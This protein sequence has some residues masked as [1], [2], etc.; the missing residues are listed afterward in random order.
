MDRDRRPLRFGSKMAKAV[1]TRF[2][3]SI[4]R[5]RPGLINNPTKRRRREKLKKSDI[6]GEKSRAKHKGIWIAQ[7]ALELHKR[8]ISPKSIPRVV[9]PCQ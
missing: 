7:I 4:L 1:K 8:A 3:D 6:G 2:R 9:G 5:S